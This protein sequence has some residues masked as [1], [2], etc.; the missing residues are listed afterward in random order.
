[1]AFGLEDPNDRNAVTRWLC[2]SARYEE[3]KRECLQIPGVG[4]VAWQK[5]L[6]E[7]GITERL[8]RERFH[9]AQ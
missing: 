1:M 8:L 5:L 4:P 7:C 6:Q 9:C 2:D 3:A